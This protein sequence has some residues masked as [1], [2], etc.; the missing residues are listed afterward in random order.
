MPKSIKD[1][2]TK[3]MPIIKLVLKLKGGLHVYEMRNKVGKV[4]GVPILTIENETK[5][6]VNNLNSKHNIN[7]KE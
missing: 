6:V 2:E 5:E 1:K 3:V 4:I 7:W